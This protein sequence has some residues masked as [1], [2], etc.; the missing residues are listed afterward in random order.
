M[1]DS[2]AMYLCSRSFASHFPAAQR[3]KNNSV[4]ATFNFDKWFWSLIRVG[5]VYHFTALYGRSFLNLQSSLIKVS[6][7]DLLPHVKTATRA[8]FRKTGKVET[9]W[10]NDVSTCCLFSIILISPSA[11]LTYEAR[12]DIH[13]EFTYTIC[14]EVTLLRLIFSPH[15]KNHHQLNEKRIPPWVR[16]LTFTLLLI[17]RSQWITLRRSFACFRRH[18]RNGWCMS[19]QMFLSGWL[20]KS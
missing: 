6:S 2:R 1:I 13:R 4:W 16:A 5:F 17:C 10:R 18:A 19:R 9:S 14:G 7:I 20:K 11:A 15:M 3:R 12:Q 8:F